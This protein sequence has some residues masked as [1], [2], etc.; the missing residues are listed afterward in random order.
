M[1]P[2]V[3]NATGGAAL[4]QAS[5]A[6]GSQQVWVI[7]VGS[8]NGTLAFSPSTISGAQVGD[9]VQFQFYPNV[10]EIKSLQL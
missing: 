5:G 8:I 2:I 1:G 7:K 6:A 10:S 3:A 4:P 9:Q